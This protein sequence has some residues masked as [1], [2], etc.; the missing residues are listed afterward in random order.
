MCM[1]FMVWECMCNAF[2]E[3]TYYGDR[4]FYKDWWNSTTFEEFNRK[5][6]KCVYNFLF[7]HCY[8]ECAFRYKFSKRMS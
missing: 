5:W 7:R 4:E 3:L 8:L 2:A 1:F 6:N